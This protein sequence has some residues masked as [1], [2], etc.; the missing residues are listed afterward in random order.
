M[1][2]IIFFCCFFFFCFLVF[3]CGFYLVLVRFIFNLL[4]LKLKKQLELVNRTIELI[5]NN[6]V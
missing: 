6:L 3:R 5:R 2:L 4:I 1:I